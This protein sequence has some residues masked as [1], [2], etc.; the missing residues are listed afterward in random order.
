[1]YEIETEDFYKDISADVKDKSDTSNC[2]FNHLSGIPVGVNKKVLGMMKDEADGEI[3]DEFVGLRA[4]FYSYKML[5][6][7]E[8]KKYKG[9]KKYV[10]KKSIAHE[11]YKNVCLRELNNLGR[12]M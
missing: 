9:V 7:K 10:V 2:P 8:N 4:K 5:E 12:C 3:N 6:G 11:D 1:M